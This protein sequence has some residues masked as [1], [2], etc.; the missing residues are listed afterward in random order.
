MSEEGQPTEVRADRGQASAWDP[1]AEEK[2]GMAVAGASS[3]EVPV[4]VIGYCADCDASGNH[5]QQKAFEEDSTTTVLLSRGAVVPLRSALACGQNL[6]LMNLR[7]NRYA[8]CRVSHLRPAA[9]V[10]YVEIEFTHYIPDFWGVPFSRDAASAM[11]EI[12]TIAAQLAAEPLPA[13]AAPNVPAAPAKALAA[14]AGAAVTMEGSVG[15]TT[16]EETEATVIVRRPNLNFEATKPARAPEFFAP[17]PMECIAVGDPVGEPMVEPVEAPAAEY[18]DA[19]PVPPVMVAR[20]ASAPAPR[21]RRG[22][23]G[24]VAAGAALLCAIAAGYYLYFPAQAALPGPAR[25]PEAE[26]GASSPLAAAADAPPESASAGDSEPADGG[27]VV[28]VPAPDIEPETTPN[29][30]VVLVSRMIL[31]EENAAGHSAAAPELHVTMRAAPPSAGDKSDGVLGPIASAPPPPPEEAPASPATDA[32]ALTPARLASSVQPI[33]P[34]NAKRLGIEGDVVIQV[35]IG[36]SGEVTK[37]N[38]QSGPGELRDA[39]LQAVKQWKYEPAQLRG[40]PTESTG[41]VT[42]KFRLR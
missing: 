17:R 41:V 33:Y 28:S 35:T 14:A 15:Q 42:L 23:S 9:N 8:H 21:K 25:A 38:V 4:R 22:R 32:D 34:A 7:S 31:P 20:S 39:A 29:Q 12:A 36:A 27:A 24:R 40:Q 11:S 30:R 13:A 10:N 2:R 19:A 26:N 1:P 37:L 5:W 3:Q 6:M 18:E 16:S